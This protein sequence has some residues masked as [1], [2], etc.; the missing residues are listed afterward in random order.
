MNGSVI[1]AKVVNGR[2]TLLLTTAI[3]T[4]F[5]AFADMRS[6]N[7]QSV[8]GTNVSPGPIQTPHWVVGGTLEVGPWSNGALAITGGGTVTGIDSVYIGNG[9]TGQ[10]TVVVSGQD[11]HGNA[12]TLTNTQTIYIGD[13]GSGELHVED[14][15]QVNSGWANVGNR[16]GGSGKAVV[17]GVGASGTA[18]VWNIT[19]QLYVGDEGTGEVRVENGGVMRTDQGLIG[20]Y[21]GTG[22]VTVSGRNSNG[23]ASTWAA[24]NNIYVGYTGNGTL[25]VSDG[26]SVVSSLPGGGAASVFIGYDGGSIGAVTVSSS[27]G[28]V[29]RLSA[30]D[31]VAV[32]YY[33]A[34]TMTIEKGGVVTGS[35][36]TVVAYG[37]GSTGTLHLNGDAGGR[38]VLETGSVIKGAGSATLDLNGGILRALRNEENFLNGFTSLTVATGGAWF[39]TNSYDITVSTNFSG[40]SSFNKLGVGQLTLTGDSSGFTGASTVS[41]GTL[42]VNGVL[43]GDMLVDPNGR[44]VGTGR[45]GNVV[46]NGIV[47][48][49]YGGEIGTLTVQGNYVGNGGR[50]EIVTVLG[51]D[52]SQTSRLVVDGGTSGTTHVGVVNRGGLGAQ[53]VQGIRIIEVGGASNGSF[54]L[55]GDYI[56]QGAPAVIAGA[57]SYRLYKGSVANPSDGNWYL[58]SDLTDPPSPPNPP[59]T[60]PPP[61]NPPPTNPPP[62]NPPPTNPPPTNPPPTTPPPTNPPPTNPPLPT[63]PPFSG[64][65]Y[66]PGVPIYEVYGANLQALN[67]LPTLQQRVGNRIWAPGAGTDGNGIWGRAEGT[68]GRFNP[69]VSTSGLY[70]SIDT[71][72]MQTGVDGVL[73]DNDRSGRLVASVNATYGEA[74][75]RIRSIFGNGAVRT[76]GYGL[77]ASLTWYGLRGFYVDGQAQASFYNS[78]LNSD[79][80]GTL[81]RGNNGH[82][83]AFSLEAGQRIPVGDRL[84][85]TPQVQVAYSNVRF[86]QF[87]D[88]V[89]AIVGADRNGSLK[90]RW[91]AAFDYQSAREGN[92]SRVYGI[93]NLSY[94]WLGGSRALVSG[95]SIDH[96]NQRLWGEFGVGASVSWR[97]NLTFYGEASADTSLDDFGNSYI[98][99]G[100]VGLR[101]QF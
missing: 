64:P 66:Q 80:L 56:F 11:S 41:G 5:S 68:H 48:P 72:K 91:G 9:P 44:L 1:V 38:G 43:G 33:G 86:D 88:A 13:E 60:N 20:S 78:S 95:I 53:T 99:K 19:N 35:R 85:I 12:S 40:S 51:D 2:R 45:V 87:A 94:E 82:G 84:G 75:S 57:Y 50:L 77:G 17:T 21:G 39:D 59:P 70:Q 97:P 71:W 29:S 81:T 8:T 89:G 49:G 4:L 67:A 14:G 58:R 90:T 25:T 63:N 31:Q 15:G 22:T 32:G 55:D 93:A 79:V 83:E 27:T 46:N 42:A 28:D 52:D 61:T 10:G 24:S 100:N 65:V 98:L 74:N 18:S 73:I 23:G 62:T 47:A 16:A 101:A 69:A 36:N 37:S 92:R 76:D 3:V 30:S 26:A 54:V 7:A 34:A 96:A 6:A